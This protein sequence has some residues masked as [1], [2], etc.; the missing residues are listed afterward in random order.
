[1]GVFFVAGKLLL[2]GFVLERGP[3]EKKNHDDKGRYESIEGTEGK[4]ETEN[5]QDDSYIHRVADIF[6]RAFAAYGVSPILLTP[7]ISG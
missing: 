3:D 4:R 6:V 5:D 1:L 7:L 2:E